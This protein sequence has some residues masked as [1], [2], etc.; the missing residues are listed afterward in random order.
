MRLTCSRSTAPAEL[1][2]LMNAAANGK[3]CLVSTCPMGDVIEYPLYRLSKFILEKRF[4]DKSQDYEGGGRAL[5]C[6]CSEDQL[7]PGRPVSDADWCE[8]AVA[9]LSRL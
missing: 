4:D 5:E 6:L 1:S 8:T 9:G 2:L 3:I 7:G